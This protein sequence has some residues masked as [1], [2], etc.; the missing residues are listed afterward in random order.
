MD[1]LADAPRSVSSD[2]D[3]TVIAIADRIYSP[4]IG[5]LQEAVDSYLV[6]NLLLEEGIVLIETANLLDLV[7]LDQLDTADACF[8]VD[9]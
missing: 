5:E 8:S 7:R 9:G 4:I 2:I 3:M 6:P 1:L